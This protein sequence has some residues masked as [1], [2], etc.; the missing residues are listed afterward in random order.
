MLPQFNAPRDRTE[1]GVIFHST[2]GTY[3]WKLQE[4]FSAAR[5]HNWGRK[6]QLQRIHQ[7]KLLLS[8]LI[9]YINF[10]F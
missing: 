6:Q 4:V 8:P 2:I 10:K 5:E 3:A 9:D 1:K 7:M